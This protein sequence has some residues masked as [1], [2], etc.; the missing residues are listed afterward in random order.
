MGIPADQIMALAARCAD[1]E[2][3]RDSL[4]AQIVTG[5]YDAASVGVTI[6]KTE[7]LDRLRAR[8]AELEELL[9]TR[10]FP[11]CPVAI[12]NEAVCNAKCTCPRGKFPPR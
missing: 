9:E 6:V 10:H 2:I 3:E 7:E 8:V 4:R 11:E 5:I 12:A 1:A